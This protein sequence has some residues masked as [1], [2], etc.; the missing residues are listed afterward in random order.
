[1]RER[2]TIAHIMLEME[3]V[4]KDEPKRVNGEIPGW[5]SSLVGCMSS[6]HKVLSQFF[7]YVDSTYKYTK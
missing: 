4:K 1:M 5:Y 2:K 7:V 6:M 3:K